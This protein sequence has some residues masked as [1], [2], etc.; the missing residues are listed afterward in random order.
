MISGRTLALD[1]GRTLSTDLSA[2]L[3]RSPAWGLFLASGLLRLI[4]FC[5]VL[6]LR[7]FRVLVGGHLTGIMI[8]D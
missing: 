4:C 1:A 5:A 2:S 7:P 6:V 8:A 3:Y